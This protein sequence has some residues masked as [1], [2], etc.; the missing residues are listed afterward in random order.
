MSEE[1]RDS[2]SVMS[3]EGGDYESVMSE[4]G[5]DSDQAAFSQKCHGLHAYM[6]ALHSWVY[7]LDEMGLLQ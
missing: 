4:E 5:G 1:G 6:C 2:D 7:V 3:E